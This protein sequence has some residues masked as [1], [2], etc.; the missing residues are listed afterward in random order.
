MHETATAVLDGNEATARIAYLTNE[1]AGI[2]PIT[3][4]SP[5]GEL[6][7]QWSAAGEKNLW[8]GVPEAVQMQ[9]EAGAAGMIH[10]TLQ[11][12]A[13]AT[14]F[15]CSQGLLLMIPDLYKIAGSL[16]PT[17]FHVAA[18]TV[19]THA[20][21]IFGDHSDVMAARATGW[22][23]LASASP[24]EAQDIALI[25]QRATLRARI[26]LIHF[27]DGFRT[28]HELRNTQ[29]V[30][31]ETIRRM[32][33]DDALAAHRARALTPEQPVLRGTTQNPDL[34]FQAREAANPHYADAPTCVQEA[35]DRFG[36]LTGR[37][38]RLFDYCGAP[39]AERVLVVMGS[40]AETA[41]EVASHLQCSG[42]PVGVLQ[43]RLYR[44][45]SATEFIAAL[46]A[47]TRR[48]AVL[49]R[50]KEPGADGEPLYKDVVAALY[51]HHAA[52]HSRFTTLPRVIGGRYGLASKEFTPGMV[53]A[54]FSELE[55]TDPGH[56]F[57]VG[58]HDDVSGTSLHWSSQYR[59]DALADTQNALFL[60]LGS[61]G[62]VS[63]AQNIA[64][65]IGDHTN[66]HVQ[67]YAVYDSRK[68]GIM[69]ASH[70][71]FARAPIRAPYLIG[72]NGAQFVACHRSELF[73]R[74]DVL[75]HAARG[76]LVLLNVSQPPEAIWD[77]LP[78]TMQHQLIDK[79]L[80]LY[81]VD[82]DRIA[83]DAGLGPRINTVMQ[84]CFF[85]L[86]GP[87]GREEAL[88]ALKIA[89]ERSYAHKGHTVVQANFAAIDAAGAALRRVPI[90]EQ[91]TNGTDLVIPVPENAPPFVREV[92]GAILAGRGDALPVS[93]MPADGTFPVGTGRLEKRALASEIPYWHPDL[94]TQCGKCPLV[95]PHA[96][97]RSKVF[98]A[99]A[100][101]Q[102]PD[103]FR[104]LPV[105]GKEF[106]PRYR[107]VYQVAPEDCT[108]CNLCIEVCPAHDKSDPGRK[109]LQPAPL[110]EIRE[111]ENENW[112][113]FL[114]LPE[115][116]RTEIRWQ[117]LR[118]AMLAEPLFEFPSACTG[119]G[120][121]PYLRLATQLFGD[122]ML[123]AN[124]TGCSS[125][126]GGNLPT[127]PYTT[128]ANGRGPAWNNSLLEDNAEHGLGFRISV[129]HQRALAGELLARL[130]DHLPAALINGILQA[131]E[132]S[133]SELAAQRARVA[134]LKDRLARINRPEARWLASIADQ[135][136]RRSIWL[137]GGDGW[138]FD[139][140]FG[141]LDHALALGRDVNILVLDTEVY[142]NTGGQTSKAT[143]RGAAAKFAAGGKQTRKKDLAAWAM[144]Y[145]NVY[146]ASVSLGA[147]DKQTLNAF[148]EAEA[149]SG[150]S[151]ILAYSPCIAHGIDLTASML[152][153]QEL[154]VQ[155]GHWPLF[156]YRPESRG[157]LVLDGKAPHLPLRAF[158]AGE[159]RFAPLNRSDPKTADTLLA[160]AQQDAA[161]RYA[162]YAQ[163]ARRGKDQGHSTE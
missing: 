2:Y 96:A 12:G 131:D 154:A 1:I 145:E 5:M 106:P 163:L 93:R 130:R 101:A 60:G 22:G 124:A 162:H 89:A 73:R 161:E 72:E 70:L 92:V 110:V 88:A 45:F 133:E 136:V 116:E 37:H 127:T 8:G 76:A 146:V 15:T 123:I 137:I 50:T 17:V 27:F 64:R 28:S 43:V 117:T 49:D 99:D 132:T 85:A 58:I 62:T 3:P 118:G 105:K 20:L 153:R 30:E 151:L 24:Q 122:R 104:S 141:G 9:S 81:A 152:H 112:S 34:Y 31:L 86:A 38:Y 95:C 39:D 107:I 142:S 42:E 35:M 44:P 54:V 7:D 66:N 159:P 143:P 148:L 33:P 19:A 135:F 63:A 10:G 147:R 87:L 47:T 114:T 13:V 36:A 51:T 32:I 156:R 18:R 57:T 94:C 138:A 16:L 149:H 128:D 75:A 119:C 82:A 67:E 155:S 68:A 59:T 120:Q 53:R 79:E 126:Y 160:A 108:G 91:V 77:T 56:P 55:A 4:A 139:I 25:A 134:E 109:G 140:G 97:I 102:A 26:P 52:G 100:E 90:P 29:L 21:S 48:I 83:R 121:T 65:I 144:T 11:T 125:I 14:T 98:P 158:T 129:D 150:P 40:G 6:F 61:D 23:L 69:T 111:A 80:A 113:F 115:H 84:A 157:E 103:T 41:V 46:P 74:H 78:R 71:R